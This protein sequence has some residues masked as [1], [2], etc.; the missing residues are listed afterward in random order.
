MKTFHTMLVA[1]LFVSMAVFLVCWLLVFT[2]LV[3]L[4]A[5]SVLSAGMAL[6]SVGLLC[7][8]EAFSRSGSHAKWRGS[9]VKVGRLSS[10]A[11]GVGFCAMGTVF[12]GYGWLPGEYRLW[13]AAV[14]LAC[15]ALALLGQFLDG[16]AYERQAWAPGP[17]TEAP[18][19]ARRLS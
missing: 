4:E 9:D 5:L 14:F 15:W 13:G 19:Q 8:G 16:R 7:L 17:K 12:L 18:D 6:L 2:R 3:E 11:F 10:F 1:A